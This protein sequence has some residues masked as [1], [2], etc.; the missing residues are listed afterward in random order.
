MKA[1]LVARNPSTG[2]FTLYAEYRHEDKFKRINTGIRSTPAKWD[3]EKEQIRLTGNPLEREEAKKQNG[4]IQAVKKNLNEAITTLFVANGNILPSIAQLNKHLAQ[5]GETIT[6][7]ATEAPLVTQLLSFIESKTDWQPATVKAFNTL[8]KHINGYEEAKKATWLLSTLSNDDIIGWQH[9]LLKEYDFNN[10]TLGKLV[11][12]L[13]TFLTDQQPS[14]INLS[15]V[16]ALYSQSLTPPVV[17]HQNEIEALQHLDLT[18]NP[19][20]ERARDLQIAQIFSGLR[21]SDLIRL[22]QRHIQKNHI[23][24]KMWKTRSQNKTVKI[25]VFPQFQAIIDKYTDSE[26]GDLLLPRLS[27]QKLND[28]I[29]EVAQLIPT[30]LKP[31]TIEFKKR[32]ITDT[33]EQPKWELISSHSS[34]RSFCSLCLDL[35]YSVKETMVWSGHS[36]LAAFS[37]YIGLSELDETAADD[38]ATRYAAKLAK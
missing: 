33:K 8:A 27:N 24:I 6:A 30:L 34:R 26:T 12:K 15:K 9:W 13:K 23:V 28:Y 4:T 19:R 31:I 2:S 29:K 17:L 14:Q 22:E 7:V 38:F 21:F 3:N 5:Q 25:P 16:K 35:G 1:K 37:R 36:T 32:N 11:G 10:A 18:A 20:L